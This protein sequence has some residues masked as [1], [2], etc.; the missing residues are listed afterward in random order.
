MSEYLG[1]LPL[2]H[3]DLYRLADA[4]DALGG[5]VVDDRQADGVTVVE[6]PDR[7]R[8]VLPRS[9]LDVVIDGSADESRTI[10]LEARGTRY[11][12]LLEGVR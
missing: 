5:G 10:R 1:R 9:R 7:M 3:V 11:R 12:R 8:D 4:S 6:W 2:F